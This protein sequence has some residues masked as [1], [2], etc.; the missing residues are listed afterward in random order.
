MV[1]FEAKKKD[2]G[3]NKEDREQYTKD[4]FKSKLKFENVKKITDGMKK[5]LEA[6]ETKKETFK[7]S[8]VEK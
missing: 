3:Y 5:E 8:E 7:L 2:M 4:Y 6:K 1:E